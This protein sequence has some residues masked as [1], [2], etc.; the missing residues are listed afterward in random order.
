MRKAAVASSSATSRTSSTSRAG[1]PQPAV[2][3]LKTT[4]T[5]PAPKSAVPSRRAPV[6]PI[7][8]KPT[9]KPAAAN[10]ARLAVVRTPQPAPRPVAVPPAL[11]DN[12]FRNSLLARRQELTGNLEDTK[13]D[14]LAKMGRVAE[15]DQAQMSHEE[16]ISLKRNSMDYQA[17]R[18]VNAAIERINTGEYGICA[19][20]EETISEK[21]LKAIPW[22]KYCVS[23]Q[24]R[25]QSRGYD[26]T[27][28]E[29][30][31]AVPTEGW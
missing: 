14:T 18:Q 3:S 21:R 31:E 23:C 10:P 22:A 4:T 9:A 26:D 28:T 25:I 13:F 12:P 7:V 16:F 19:S 30:E 27:V 20:C 2:R 5:R 6:T 29:D 1:A 17:L 11:P 15:D 24:D 8:T